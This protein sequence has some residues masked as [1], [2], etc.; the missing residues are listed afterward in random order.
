VGGDD[1]LT[2]NRIAWGTRTPF[3]ARILPRFQ[4]VDIL[5]VGCNLGAN[6][7]A[8]R[9]LKEYP[10][11]RLCGADIN[12]KAIRE[13]WKASLTVDK[14]AAIDLLDHYGPKQFDLVFTSGVL[15][16]VPPKEILRVMSQIKQV[17]RRYVLAIE[18]A[19]KLEVEV[20]Y[21]GEKEL[22]W[23][24]PYGALYDAMNLNLVEEGEAEG[25]DRC[26]YW[27]CERLL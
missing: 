24:R 9:S 22:L 21:R 1:Y 18:Y 16:H 2:R 14:C 17:S 15:I 6:L 26:H 7:L 4:P 23:R 10:F 5:E 13:A 25:F 27:L 11:G 20:T 3:W 12:D 8:I 19:D